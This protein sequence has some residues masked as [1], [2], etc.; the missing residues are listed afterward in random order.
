MAQKGQI[1]IRQER[2]DITDFIMSSRNGKTKMEER[3]GEGERKQ[4]RERERG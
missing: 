3:G 2:M 4:D 1:Y